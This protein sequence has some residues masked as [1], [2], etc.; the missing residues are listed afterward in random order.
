M[1]DTGRLCEQLEENGVVGDS[2]SRRISESG[3]EDTWTGLSIYKAETTRMSPRFRSE[4]TK[5]SQD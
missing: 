4:G 3:L 5:S 2:K 1:L